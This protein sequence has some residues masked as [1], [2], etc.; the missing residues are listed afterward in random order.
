[1]KKAEARVTGMAKHAA[2]ATVSEREWQSLDSFMA[3]RERE[4]LVD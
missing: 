1:V 4:D 3:A 2:A